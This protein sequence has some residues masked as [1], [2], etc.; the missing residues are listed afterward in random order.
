MV[1]FRIVNTGTM[2]KKGERRTRNG[3][4]KVKRKIFPRRAGKYR[5]KEHVLD[6]FGFVRD[7][8]KILYW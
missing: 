7:A 8:G 6:K 4:C 1:L 3:K 5:Q 2:K